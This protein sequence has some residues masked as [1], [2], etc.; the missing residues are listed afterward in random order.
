[1]A[2]TSSF[3]LAVALLAHAPVVDVVVDHVDLLEV[4]HYYD[5]QG[6][7]VFDQTIYYDWSPEHSRYN[8]RA[9]R[10]LKSTGQ[11]PYRDWKTGEY[12][13]VWHD[14]SIMRKVHADAFRESWTQYDPEVIER[15]YLPR[16]QRRELLK[17]GLNGVP[18]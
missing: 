13:A 15:E 12:I 9:F 16:E 7:H 14:G 10:L 17:P 8:V 4:N 2:T 11:M 3:V 1:M 18:K 6:R 5:E